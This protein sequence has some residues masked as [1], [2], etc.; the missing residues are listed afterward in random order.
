MLMA[1]S[2]TFSTTE[3]AEIEKQR[4]LVKFCFNFAIYSF[5]HL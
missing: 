1:F 5:L 2:D 4:H 3:M